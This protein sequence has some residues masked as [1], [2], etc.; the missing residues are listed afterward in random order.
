MTLDEKIE[1]RAQTTTSDSRWIAVERII[2]SRNFAKSGRLSAFLSYIVQCA[3]EDRAEG[4]SEQ[5]IGIHVFGRTPGYN[6]ADDN[7]VRTTARQLRQRLALYYQEEGSTDGLRI[8]IPRGGYIPVFHTSGSQ[9]AEAIASPSPLSEPQSDAADAPISPPSASLKWLNV[10]LL[11]LMGAALCLGIERGITFYR[12]RS[13]VT[14]PLWRELFSGSQ[15]TMFVPGD[16]GLNLFNNEAHSSTQLALR[17]YIGGGWIYS[18]V[19]K[20]PGFAGG[21]VAARRYVSISDLELASDLKGL[22]RFSRSGYRIKFPRGLAAEDFRNAN[23]ILAGAPVYN[24]WVEMFD[25]HL[26]FHIVYNGEG[27][28]TM[29]VVNRKP[30]SDEPSRY[31]VAPARQGFGYIALTDNLEG[32]GKI[33]LIEGTSHL[34]VDAAISFLFND[35]KMA[36]IIAKAKIS[37]KPISNFEVLIEANFLKG[38]S[39]EVTVLATRFYP[40]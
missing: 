9:T 25:A 12:M 7:I 1:D 29:Y 27:D 2:A 17:D 10:L 26:N 32:D 33:L 11:L 4:V 8:E 37:N 19:A 18:P 35:G 28:S 15:T 16:A 36:P 6:P 14:D 22:S 39:G 30:L 23:A 34:G 13:S 31:V 24:P 40:K 21:P 20:S 3:I 5:Q 38:N